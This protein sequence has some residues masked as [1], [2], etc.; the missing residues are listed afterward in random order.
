MI[1]DYGDIEFKDHD[2][3]RD[4]DGVEYLLE[5]IHKNT[6]TGIFLILKAVRGN[7]VNGRVYVKIKDIMIDVDPTGFKIHV[8]GNLKEAKRWICDNFDR[9]LNLCED[10]I[11]MVANDVMDA[12]GKI[13]EVRRMREE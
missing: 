3:H 10:I 11:D 13:A 4:S 7:G 6:P 2:R 8:D 12:R 9:V 5:I 1:P